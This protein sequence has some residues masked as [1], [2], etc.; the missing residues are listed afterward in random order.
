MVE[1]SNVIGRIT[2]AIIESV[3]GILKDAVSKNL[4]RNID[5]KE[6]IAKKAQR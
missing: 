3:L 5:V 1:K 2:S 6:F 4:A